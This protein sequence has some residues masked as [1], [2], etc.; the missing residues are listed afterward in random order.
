[1]HDAAGGVNGMTPQSEY[2]IRVQVTDSNSLD[3]LVSLVVSLY[4]DPA[5][6]YDFGTRPT[7]GNTQ[8]CAIMTW[9]NAN[10]D[11]WTIDTG[12]GSTTWSLVTGKCYPPSMTSTTGY[13][14][15]YFMPGKVAAE[16]KQSDESE[17]DV[18]AIASDH[19]SSNGNGLEGQTMNWYGEITNVTSNASWSSVTLS[20]VNISA[21]AGISAT[22]IS[23]GNYS[24]QIFASTLWSI[25]GSA[26]ASLNIGGALSSGQFLLRAN[27]TNNLL[28][29]VQVYGVG[30][31]QTVDNTRTI[32]GEIGSTPSNRLWLSLSDSLVP[33]RYTGTVSYKIAYRL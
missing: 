28:A 6:L 7:A 26:N 33:G 17:W 4:Y 32:T 25:N 19:S 8:T 30:N 13:F 18:Y 1:V 29:S 31:P 3:D 12:V 11:T 9:T 5:H 24:E 14:D 22:Y 15:F 23:N 20:C 10:P 21:D 16:T 27:N 2:F